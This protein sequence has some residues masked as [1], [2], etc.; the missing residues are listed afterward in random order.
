MT[1][2]RI[3]FLDIETKPAQAYVWRL[4]D[5][6]VSLEQLIEPG[7]VICFGAKW[8]GDKEM[9]FYS[10]WEHGHENM[11]AAAKKLLDEAD[12][13]VTYNG[14]RFDIPKL[15]G[16]FASMGLLAPAP[17]TSIDVYKSVKKLGLTSSKLA[18]VGPFFKIGKKIKHAGFSLWVGVMNGNEQDQ[19]RMRRYCIQDV[20]LLER[21]YTR[22]KPFIHNHP[23][24]GDV[25]SD[26][27]GACGSSKVHNRGFR[28]T[29]AYRIQ[30]RQCQAC[31]SWSDGKRTKV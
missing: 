31:G 8:L 27:C 16:E 15:R 12:A 19:R 17:I 14:D 1:K 22:L 11:V 3:L 21:V 7:G 4:F 28:R 30:R 6:N 10:D 5:E 25:K 13:V 9:H 24:M 23:H 20:R 2:P 29:K 18:F 26:A